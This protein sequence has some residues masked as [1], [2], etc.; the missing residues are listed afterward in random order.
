MP[1]T[2]DQIDEVLFDR[3]QQLIRRKTGI[4]LTG[5]AE[6]S[7]RLKLQN[8]LTR[9]L[10]RLGLSNLTEYYQLLESASDDAPAWL[11]FIHAVST[12]KTGFFRESQHF[13]ILAQH[14][15]SRWNQHRTP[16]QVWSAACSTGEEP[17][18]I[19]ITLTDAATSSK[20]P[21]AHFQILAT[22][23]DLVVLEEAKHGIYL[24]PDTS[25]VSRETLERHFL[26]GRN[27]K[28]GSVKVK[29]SIR[30]AV[31]YEQFNL[32]QSNY[33][34]KHSFD[35]IFCRN[36]LIYFDPVER[37]KL[38]TQLARCLAPGGLLFF[39]HAESF[40]SRA[41]L[42]CVAPTVYRVKRGTSQP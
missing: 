14:V 28:T 37:E 21:T 9:P 24:R 11:E 35:A 10:K 32:L 16:L 20:S 29:D 4:V 25:A 23:I 26:E 34:N 12:H 8:R 7:R 3:Y 38:V 22:D 40:S 31:R 17:Y 33:T 19:A 13:Q 2:V 30:D 42:D 27:R 15:E 18:S 1:N 36:V 5:L 6:R 39:G 41:D